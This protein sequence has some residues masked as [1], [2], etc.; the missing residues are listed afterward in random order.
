[1]FKSYVYNVI[2]IEANYLFQI[3]LLQSSFKDDFSDCGWSDGKIVSAH[4]GT[5]DY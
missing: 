3:L 2:K 5:A 4:S 1:M